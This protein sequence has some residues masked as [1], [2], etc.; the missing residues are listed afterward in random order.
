MRDRTKAVAVIACLVA[1]VGFAMAEE[2]LTLQLTNATSDVAKIEVARGK[3]ADCDQNAAYDTLVLQPGQTAKIPFGDSRVICW[4]SDSD[5]EGA[6]WRSKSCT[7]ESEDCR[8]SL[9]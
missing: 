8:A 2:E 6:V 9:Q 5:A 4:R 1:A 3:T 7:Q